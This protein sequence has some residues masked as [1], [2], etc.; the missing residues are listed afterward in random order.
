MQGI[1][2]TEHG[3]GALLRIGDAVGRMRDY[4]FALGKAVDDAGIRAN[5]LG[6]RS[7]IRG[8]LWVGLDTIVPLGLPHV[9]RR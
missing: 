2:T 4:R 6:L 8:G 3:K 7:A 5:V 1:A 9:V